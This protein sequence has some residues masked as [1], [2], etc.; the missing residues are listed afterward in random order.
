MNKIIRINISGALPAGNIL[1]R[2]GNIMNPDNPEK[3]YNI[4]IETYNNQSDSSSKVE[5]APIITLSYTSRII[6]LTT[7]NTVYTVNHQPSTLVIF[8]TPGVRIPSGSLLTFDF[9]ADISQ[10]VYKSASINSATVTFSPSKTNN[11]ITL[12]AS[13]QILSGSNVTLIF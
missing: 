3:S 13:M 5:S 12:T 7:S 11:T 4:I 8:Y 9:S 6:N 10:P 1:V 2:L